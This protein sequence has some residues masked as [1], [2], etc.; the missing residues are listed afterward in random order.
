MHI[1]KIKTKDAQGGY[2]VGSTSLVWVTFP[3]QYLYAVYYRGRIATDRDLGVA[4]G[5]C[6]AA[7]A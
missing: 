7:A 6:Y 1:R 5:K 4:I 2:E 3:A